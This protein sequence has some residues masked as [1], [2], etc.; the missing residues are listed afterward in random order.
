MAKL[1][2]AVLE[3]KTTDEETVFPLITTL[4]V[5]SPLLLPPASLI[6]IWLRVTPPWPA[7]VMLTCKAITLVPE[8]TF[9]VPAEPEPK[10][11]DEEVGVE[12]TVSVLVM[13]A[14]KVG[15]LETV[16]VPV[17]VVVTV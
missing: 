17:K 11:S 10:F 7:T 1:I 4:T 13:V 12:V 16:E 14:V 6:V 3:T 8:R 5:A 9:K 15:V 2:V